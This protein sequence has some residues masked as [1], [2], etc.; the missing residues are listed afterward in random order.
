MKRSIVNKRFKNKPVPTQ[1]Q[2]VRHQ[3]NGS[4][5][6][7]QAMRNQCF[8]NFLLFLTV[9]KAPF[10]R[11]SR[12]RIQGVFQKEPCSYIGR[13]SELGVLLKIPSFDIYRSIAFIQKMHNSNLHILI[14]VP[15]QSV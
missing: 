3:P 13:F 9:S 14:E 10:R 2:R 1:K 4:I 12:E 6:N 15:K 11:Q 5:F 8:R 7:H